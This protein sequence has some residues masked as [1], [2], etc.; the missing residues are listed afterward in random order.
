MVGC[1]YG[2]GPGTP[3]VVVGEGVNEGSMVR[4]AVLVS[5]GE[6]V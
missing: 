1:D 5:V 2:A 6:G 4:V 3:I